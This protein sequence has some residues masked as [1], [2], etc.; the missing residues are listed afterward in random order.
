MNA[1]LQ[2]TRGVAATTLQLKH[3]R[4]WRQDRSVQ[5]RLISQ[6]CGGVCRGVPATRHSRS[7]TPA[8]SRSCLRSALFA[9]VKL[10]ALVGGMAAAHVR[11]QRRC[12]DLLTRRECRYGARR[13]GYLLLA[14]FQLL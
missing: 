7:G 2:L 4:V 9:L 10:M 13:L 12:C 1:P 3:L 11:G 6:I 8:G 5:E 14:G